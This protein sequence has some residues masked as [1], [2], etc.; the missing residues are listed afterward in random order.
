M[1][2]GRVRKWT[3]KLH[4]FKNQ[5]GAMSCA[6]SPTPL[7]ETKQFSSNFHCSRKSPLHLSSDISHNPHKY[8]HQQQLCCGC[9]CEG[10]LTP[11]LALKNTLLFN[12]VVSIT[13]RGRGLHA[14]DGR[15]HSEKVH[16]WVI[17]LNSSAANIP[18]TLVQPPC[19]LQRRKVFSPRHIN[20]CH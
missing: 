5:H 8:L 11:Y 20:R 15:G 1:A 9:G 18:K 13:F 6:K 14:R 7:T 12:P 2:H 17:I 16:K 3:E 4:L 19:P 10:S